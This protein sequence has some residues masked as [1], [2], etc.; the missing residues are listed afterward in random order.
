MPRNNNWVCFA[1]RVVI[2]KPS[3]I[4]Q[5]PKCPDCGSE[6]FFLGHKVE[7][8]NQRNLRAWRELHLD[9]RERELNRR[10]KSSQEKVRRTHDIEQEIARIKAL[11]ENAGRRSYIKGLE[12]WLKKVSTK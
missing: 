4:T 11:P 6:C 2:R 7:V 3:G 1:C 5:L 8:P 12:A 9:C 10:E